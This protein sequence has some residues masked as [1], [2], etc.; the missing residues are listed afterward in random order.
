MLLFNKILPAFFLP[1]GLVIILLLYALVRVK[2]WPV[3]VALVILYLASI[4]FIGDRLVGSL[5]SRYPP[6]AINQVEA[7]DAIVVLG[8]IF[9]PPATEGMLANVGE[10]GER[11]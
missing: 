4:P 8:G 1:L 3:L 2:R 7:A 10:T 9:G 5:E 6:V 11:L